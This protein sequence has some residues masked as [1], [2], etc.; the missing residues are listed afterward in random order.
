MKSQLTLFSYDKNTANHRH[1]T[2]DAAS[3][4]PMLDEP[5]NFS[6]VC[7][8]RVP[9]IKLP[10]SSGR[11][12]RKSKLQSIM[13]NNETLVRAGYVIHTQCCEM[14][15]VRSRIFSENF[16]GSRQQ[17]ELCRCAQ[18]MLVHCSL[19]QPCPMAQTHK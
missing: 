5:D 9:E 18:C 12:S 8:Q 4:S 17:A 10:E 3:I 14:F 19:W 1:V 16:T 6:F 11:R 15:N 7:P 13:V 2:A